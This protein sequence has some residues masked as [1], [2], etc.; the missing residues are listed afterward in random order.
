MSSAAIQNPH[1]NLEFLSYLLR[2]VFPISALLNHS[3]L[4][5]NNFSID[6]D[7]NAVS[8]SWNKII[9]IDEMPKALPMRLTRFLAEEEKVIHGNLQY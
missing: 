5:L 9:K 8:E 1:Y 6:P 4:S 7:T 3:L 2:N